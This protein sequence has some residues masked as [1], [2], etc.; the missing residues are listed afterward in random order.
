MWLRVAQTS[1]HGESIQIMCLGLPDSDNKSRPERVRLDLESQRIPEITS[2]PPYLV[3]TVVMSKYHTAILT[4][5]PRNNLLLCGF[6][7][8]GRLGTGKV[9]DTQLTPIAVQWPEY[10]VAVALGRDHTIALSKSGN[11]ITFGNNRFGQLGYETD[12]GKDETPMQLV[13]RK[14][15]AAN[16][17]R[18]PIIGV[19]ASSVHSVVY[20][21][22]DI[23]T[24]GYNQGQLGKRALLSAHGAL[25]Y[26]YSY[27]F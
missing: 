23:Y 27:T 1:T 5:E 15:Q 18:L 9:V 11:V 7:R 4:S 19:A 17:K 8:G 12:A 25:L 10:I 2:R 24:F 22:S 6:G 14:I 26:I 20:T 16:L 13:P 21:S 3:R